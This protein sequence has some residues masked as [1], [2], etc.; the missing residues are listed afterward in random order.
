MMRE[1]LARLGDKDREVLYL[2]YL[3]G[4]AFHEITAVLGIS[5]SATKVRPFRALERLR[6]LSDDE[7]FAGLRA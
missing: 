6:R 1:S 2:C 5:E 7:E 4:V 3:E